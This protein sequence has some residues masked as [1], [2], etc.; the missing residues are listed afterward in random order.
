[1]SAGE[2]CQTKK[3][4]GRKEGE[5]LEL[6]PKGGLMVSHSDK[7]SDNV[8]ESNREKILALQSEVFK[9]IPEEITPIPSNIELE[10]LKQWKEKK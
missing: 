10:M 1:M 9:Y 2:F 6:Y 7:C 5:Q 3:S 4:K 8:P